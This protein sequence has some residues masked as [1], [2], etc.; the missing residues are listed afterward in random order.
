ML[1]DKKIKFIDSM[2][3]RD[4]IFRIWVGLL[5]LAGQTNENGVI[6]LSENMPYTEEMLS[7][8][9]SRDVNIVRLALD[10]LKKFDMIKVYENN[11]IYITNWE[12]HQNVE[13]L[14]KIREQRRLRQQKYRSKHKE[15]EDKSKKLDK[16]LE[17][18]GNVD[19]GVTSNVTPKPKKKKEKVLIFKCNPYLGVK[20]FFE[21]FLEEIRE[22]FKKELVITNYAKETAAIKNIA[23][24]IESNTKHVKDDIFDGSEDL[25]MIIKRAKSNWRF[26]NST[27]LPSS[28]YQ[29]INDLMEI[30]NE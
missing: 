11:I 2:P 14:E 26:R 27:P 1:D 17:I 28:I 29:A 24:I 21:F 18:E 20:D 30:R 16:E 12:K 13:G 19:S 23:K 15:L 8:L 6:Y 4:A 5:A 10:T 3:E 9:F 7:T 25:A 22:V